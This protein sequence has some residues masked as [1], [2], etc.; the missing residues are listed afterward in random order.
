MIVL[1]DKSGL[2]VPHPR[3]ATGPGIA[4]ANQSP[5]RV[6]TTPLAKRENAQLTGQAWRSCVYQVSAWE[7]NVPYVDA[8]LVRMSDYRG[9]VTPYPNTRDTAWNAEVTPWLERTFYN[10]TDFDASGKFTFEEFQ[11]QLWR[12][13]DSDGDVLAVQMK[14]PEQQDRPQWRMVPAL[15]V[16]SPGSGNANDWIDGIKVGPH[17]KALAYH[18]LAEESAVGWRV[19]L[20][21]AGYVVDRADAFHFAN[22]RKVG[23]SRG[24]TVFLSSGSTI[25]DLAMLDSSLHRIFNLATKLAITFETEA[26]SGKGAL[27]MLEGAAVDDTVASPSAVDEA[28]NAIDVA[29]FKELF[30]GDGPVV[31]ELEPGQKANLHGQDRDLPDV[32]AV[33]AADL[34]R[35]AM[36]YGGLPV[37]VLLCIYSGAFNLTGPGFR[38]ALTSAVRWREGQLRKIEPWV[39]RAYAAHIAWGLLTKQIPF[40][41]KDFRPFECNT[42][43]EKVIGIDEGRD[44]RLDQIRLQIGATDEAEIAHEYGRNLDDVIQTRVAFIEKV[45]AS[46]G[47]A[48]SP[49]MWASQWKGGAALNLNAS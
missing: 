49:E 31:S 39:K 3:R 44:V 5:V 48:P 2:P 42:R 32:S 19:P 40:P 46:F 9:A 34:E 22:W 20:N 12:Y 10:N 7:A 25:V 33:R 6:S 4:M 35:I 13:R 36:A 45:C 14:D 1:T 15:G 23:R 18:V 38:V 24:T 28:G 30:M 43:W 41:K 37:Q 11:K 26:G 8:A 16:D 21:R 29:R 17:H 47:W 27:K